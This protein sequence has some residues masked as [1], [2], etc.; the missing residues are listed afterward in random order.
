MSSDPFAYSRGAG[1]AGSGSAAPE[2][3]SFPQQHSATPVGFQPQQPAS[4]PAA[5]SNIGGGGGGA[6]GVGISAGGRGF[7]PTAAPFAAA[8]NNNSFGGSGAFGGGGDG[9]LGGAQRGG[10]ADPYASSLASMAR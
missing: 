10:G 1:H 4:A 2:W 6:R 9:G 5:V 8:S 7:A 3:Q